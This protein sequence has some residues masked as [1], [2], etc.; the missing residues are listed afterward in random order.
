MTDA[1]TAIR[2]SSARIENRILLVCTRFG[3]TNV[4]AT[5]AIVFPIKLEPDWSHHLISVH[6]V[7]RDQASRLWSDSSVYGLAYPQ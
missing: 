2:S 4:K 6:S 3:P 7:E 1:T 5:K